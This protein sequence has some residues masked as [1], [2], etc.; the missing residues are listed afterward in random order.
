M[1]KI[2]LNK[3]TEQA[4]QK[5]VA[6]PPHSLL[7]TGQDGVGKR[8]V[9]LWLAAELLKVDAKDVLEHPHVY[10]IEPRGDTSPSISI[11]DIRQLE[12]V[13]SLKVPSPATVSRII[14]IDSA[15]FMTPE[16]QNALLK[17]LEEPPKASILILTC[18]YAS[19]V[20][21]TIQSRTQVLQITPPSQNDLAAALPLEG[22]A[23]QQVLALSG[24]LP[25]I[26]FSL[27]SNDESHPYVKAANTARSLLQQSTFEKLCV[28][29]SLSKDKQHC[30]MTLQLMIQM[31]R[32]GLLNGRQ[33]DRWRRIMEA[34]Y[35][36]Q[37]SINRGGQLK[38][39]LS[40]FMLSI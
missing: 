8:T 4:L 27:T 20:L 6:N 31:A 34:A 40:N 15:Q 11:E 13:L 24:G 3:L 14:L 17:T 26:A 1:K 7:I 39:V 25:G 32:A 2:L 18:P 33:Q 5:V 36:A 29:D 38:L 16:A 19:G 35:N 37:L 10:S 9:A 21:P 28:V 30:Q 23:L 12:H 22:P